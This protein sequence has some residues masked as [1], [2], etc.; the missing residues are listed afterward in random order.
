MTWP[1]TRPLYSKAFPQTAQTDIA[2]PYSLFVLT[3]QGDEISA[4]TWFA[5]SSV[6][7]H[8]GL[9]RMPR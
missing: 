5:D 6:F 8:F 4:I 9:P 7:S 3:L 1:N 2:R